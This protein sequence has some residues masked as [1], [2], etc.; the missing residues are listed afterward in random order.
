MKVRSLA[1]ICSIAF[2]FAI[3]AADPAQSVARGRVVLI[4]IDGLRP[5]FYLADPLAAN[6]ATLQ[7]MMHNGS[8]A[9]AV[10]PPYP[11]F[12][13]PGHTSIVTGTLPARHGVTN[14]STLDPTNAGEHWFWFASQIKVPTIWDVA[15][16]A[17]L[18]V[19]AVSWPVSAGSKSIDW[20][21]PEFATRDE[22]FKQFRTY[23]RPDLLARVERRNGRLE[24]A[25]KLTEATWD[26]VIA[27][28]AIDLI[29]DQK[30]D[31]L[32]VHFIESD[33]AQ[34]NGGREARD[35]PDVLYRIDTH[36]H[37]I[38]ESCKAAGTFEQTTFIVTGD[39]GFANVDQGVAP[40]VLLA[41]A[42]LI[43]HEP[44]AQEIDER[45][46]P[47]RKEKI[48]DWKAYVEN[49]GGSAGIYIR[50]ASDTK[51]ADKVLKILEEHTVDPQTKRPLYRIIPRAELEKLGGPAD[52][53]AYLEGEKGITFSGEVV[54]GFVRE[55]KRKGNHGFLPSKPGLQTG[56]VAM[57][58]GIRKGTMID[59]ARLIDIAPTVAALLRLKFD[60]A[61]GSALREILE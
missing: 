57:G 19:A 51:T 55:T 43:Q 2:G 20:N 47:H 18:V 49:T 44:G 22:G 7:R 3:Q 27:N 21:F 14:N 31:L 11:S 26:N 16:N 36:V 54:G 30:P 58:R 28:T 34:H 37:D 45:G 32:F 61:E 50:D 39:H 40:N 53:L 5:E 10:F 12:T 9:R 6:C 59:Q 35:L 60:S 48:T 23:T 29:K 25:G 33:H 13:Y 52:A 1:C 17:G 56:L 8:A 4:T 38:I 42:G 24:Q 46:K 15:H 41:E